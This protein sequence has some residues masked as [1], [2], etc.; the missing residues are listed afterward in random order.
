MA[1]RVDASP[2][3]LCS[4]AAVAA[5][6]ALAADVA[7]GAHPTHVV[8]LV[9]VAAVVASV[10]RLGRRA[11]AALPTVSAA[12]AAQPVLHV[13]SEAARPETVA[14]D[15]R[16]LVQH[17]LMSEVP[18]A[19]VQVAVPAVAVITVTLVAHLLYLLIDAVRRPLAVALAAPCTA[20]HVLIPVRARRLGSMLRWCGWVLQAGRRGPPALA[21]YG[22]S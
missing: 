11:T 22:I 4:A 5:G 8:V 19:G 10:R 2:L 14:P 3:L 1:R 20:P 16:D 17:L 18:T 13:T 6:C 12:L 7:H 15:H 21:T 9:V